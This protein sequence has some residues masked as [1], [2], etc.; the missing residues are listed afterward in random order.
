VETLVVIVVLVVTAYR[1]AIWVERKQPDRRRDSAHPVVSGNVVA[2]K[3]TFKSKYRDFDYY[4]QLRVVEAGA[5]CKKKVMNSEEYHCFA[6]IER[7]VKAKP[8]RYRVLPQ[9]SL[10]AFITASSD[11][12]GRAVGTKR[13]DI[14]VISPTGYPILVVEYQGGG[15]HRNNAAA[16]DAIKKEALRRAGVPF[17][18]VLPSDDDAE[19]AHKVER[20]ANWDHE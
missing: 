12:A 17:L 4:E 18:E 14:T 13:A 6:V 10:G 5:F 16:R 3:S 11:E 20:A 7:V 15:H 1:L 9:V 8:R 2:Q 19:I